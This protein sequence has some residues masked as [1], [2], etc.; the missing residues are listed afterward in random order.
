[1]F[2][3]LR[4]MGRRRSGSGETHLEVV[5]RIAAGVRIIVGRYRAMASFISHKE[6]REK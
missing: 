2:W 1:M 5:L 6:F 4:K 3:L